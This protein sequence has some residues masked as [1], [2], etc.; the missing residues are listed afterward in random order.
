MF[1]ELLSTV[2]CRQTDVVT[3]S[4]QYWQ[5]HTSDAIVFKWDNQEK[6]IYTTCAINTL[7]CF[8]KYCILKE[9]LW[10]VNILTKPLSLLNLCLPVR[11]LFVGSLNRMYPFVWTYSSDFIFLCFRHLTVSIK[12]LCYLAVQPPLSSVCWTDRVTMISRELFEQSC[13]NLQEIFTSHYWSP[14]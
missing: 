6:H 1:L 5:Q 13:W 14:H 8:F 7:F 2:F 4:Y 3:L 12:A 10:R 11:C 9:D